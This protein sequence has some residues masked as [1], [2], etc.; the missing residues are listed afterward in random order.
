[1]LSFCHEKARNLA[2]TAKTRGNEYR[3]WMH[4]AG[5]VRG[6]WGDEGDCNAFHSFGRA[7]P[8]V[9]D[10]RKG[11]GVDKKKTN[12]FIVTKRRRRKVPDILY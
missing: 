12:Q 10:R 2:G 6:R 5:K 1:M 3:G 8:S 4:A 9:A 11:A 7:I